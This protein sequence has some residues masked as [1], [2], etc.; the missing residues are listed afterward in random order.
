MDKVKKDELVK[1][2]VQEEKKFLVIIRTPVE[3][4]EQSNSETQLFN[5]RIDGKVRGKYVYCSLAPIDK[6]GYVCLDYVFGDEDTA[7]LVLKPFS[8]TQE[9]GN[10]VSGYTF[11]ARNVDKVSG[12]VYE[13]QVKPYKG[14]DKSILMTLLQ[15]YNLI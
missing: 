13:C 7:E 14:S 11:M 4:K 15:E 12:K 1:E 3:S 8:I 10:V 2:S 6:G 5:Y 9:D